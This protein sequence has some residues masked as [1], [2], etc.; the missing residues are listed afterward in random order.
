[1]PLL[2]HII[3]LTS[4]RYVSS[5]FLHCGK[6]PLFS[7][8]VFGKEKYLDAALK[9]GEV[10]WSHGLLKKGYGICH[11]V[12]GNAYTFL[13]LF[14]QTGDLKYLHRAI[15]VGSL[16]LS[17]LSCH[18]KIKKTLTNLNMYLKTDHLLVFF[19]KLCFGVI[20]KNSKWVKRAPLRHSKL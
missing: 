8:K 10:V 5:H 20:L 3:Y 1:M 14:R 13:C 17:F 4:I 18:H 16:D 12:A 11:G 2:G 6:F 15:K 7:C 9:C 19:T